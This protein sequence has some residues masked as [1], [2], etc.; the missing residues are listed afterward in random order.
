MLNGQQGQYVRVV[1]VHR[2]AVINYP[3][4]VDSAV[5]RCR[6]VTAADQRIPASWEPPA[7]VVP[8]A[9]ASALPCSIPSRPDGRQTSA[10]QSGPGVPP[11]KLGKGPT[12]LLGGAVL[13][14]SCH[15]MR[16]TSM[17]RCDANIP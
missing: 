16:T 13:L 8:N 15:Y 10:G 7:L 5:E 6:E 4:A 2:T 14:H 1:A 11:G 3:L 17:G 9:K 12:V